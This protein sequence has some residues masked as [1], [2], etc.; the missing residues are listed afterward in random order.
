MMQIKMSTEI[1]PFGGDLTAGDLATAIGALPTHANVSVETWDSQR[2]G[3][4]W[5]VRASWLEDR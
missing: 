2:D 5:R 1:G 3:N 4:G